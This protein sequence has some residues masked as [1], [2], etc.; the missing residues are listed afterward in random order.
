MREAQ[1]ILLS[2]CGFLLLGILWVG[3]PVE[4]SYLIF[5]CIGQIICLQS[6]IGCFTHCATNKATLPNVTLGTSPPP[7]PI[8]YYKSRRRVRNYCLYRRVLRRSVQRRI[9]DPPF[10]LLQPTTWFKC[11][12]NPTQVDRTVAPLVTQPRHLKSIRKR[13]SKPPSYV[14]LSFEEEQWRCSE[15]ERIKPRLL[16]QSWIQYDLQFGISLDEFLSDLDP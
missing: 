14:K 6:F 5:Q 9:R 12:R 11:R 2:L 8:G 7:K 4:N 1:D 13:Q 3:F 10:T 16:H 15:Y